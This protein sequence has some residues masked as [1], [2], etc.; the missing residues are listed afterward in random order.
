MLVQRK[1]TGASE[2]YFIISCQLFK[3]VSSHNLDFQLCSQCYSWHHWISILAKVTGAGTHDLQDLNWWNTR[4]QRPKSGY[5]PTV[6]HWQDDSRMA[7]L[8]ISSSTG[9]QAEMAKHHP[10]KHAGVLHTPPRVLTTGGVFGSW[11]FLGATPH[12]SKRRSLVFTGEDMTQSDTQ[13]PVLTVLQTALS[14]G[15]GCIN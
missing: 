7:Q 8:P 1:Q 4:K 6:H 15:T 10:S 11:D 12:L 13:T 5:R 9:K 2:V 3:V 14:T